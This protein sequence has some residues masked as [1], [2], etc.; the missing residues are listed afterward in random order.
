MLLSVMLSSCSY[1]SLKPSYKDDYVENTLLTYAKQGNVDAQKLIGQME[2][3]KNSGDIGDK[4]AKAWQDL[5]SG[6]KENSTTW[7]LTAAQ[8]GSW[9]AQVMLGQIADMG[10]SEGGSMDV[11][12]ELLRK[13]A[14][15][16][17]DFAEFELIKRI[18]L[19]KNQSY[20]KAQE[21]DEARWTRY[22]ERDVGM[23]R[24]ML[25]IS[26]MYF[27]GY[28][29]PQDKTKSAFWFDK[30]MDLIAS[31]VDKSKGSKRVLR[32]VYWALKIYDRSYP[33]NVNL[34]RWLFKY[35]SEGHPQ[36]QYDLAM[37]LYLGEG[38]KQNKDE[39]YKWFLK[40]AEQGY[41]ESMFIVG[42]AYDRGG[43]LKEDAE[44]ASYWYK[45]ASEQNYVRAQMALA[46]M[47][48]QGRGVTKDEAMAEKL[49]DKAIY[50]TIKLAIKEHKSPELE[51]VNL[52]TTPIIGIEDYKEMFKW[53]LKAA[54]KGDDFAQYQTAQMLENGSGTEK[55]IREAFYWYKNSAD[56]GNSKALVRIA[57]FYMDKDNGVVI[58]SPEEAIKWLMIPAEKKDAE[59]EYIL[60]LTYLQGEDVQI[61]PGFASKWLAMAA[62]QG[63]I[64]AGLTIARAYFY[65]DKLNQDRKK[66]LH[67]FNMVES[68]S[69]WDAK[70]I[71]DEVEI[72][73]LKKYKHDGL[74]N[75]LKEVGKLY[76]L[77]HMA[78]DDKDAEAQYQLARYFD[79]G[80][81]L[82]ITDETESTYWYETASKKG[83]PK[84]QFALAYRYYKGDDVK[85]NPEYSAKIMRFAA[86]KDYAPAEAYMG[87]Y[88][89]EGYGVEKNVPYGVT[90]YSKA[91]RQN[92][93]EAE[94]ALGKLYFEGEVVEKNWR[95][96][97]RLFR[98]AGV[99]KH[100]ESINHYCKI[101]D[102]SDIIPKGEP[103][104]EVWCKYEERKQNELEN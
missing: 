23:L 91:V 86:D 6:E 15:E 24:Y 84:A 65:G 34:S 90:F 59:A 92:Y 96:A 19:K 33:A 17:S 101:Y 48:K 82:K 1:F 89:V 83:Y 27:E 63:H 5:G 76:A 10:R 77:Y 49:I 61:N 87:K 54:R 26:R 30:A 56:N 37:A 47:M 20:A 104:A 25:G 94:Y 41:P 102:A 95:L 8:N 40:S 52:F 46:Y 43:D 14:K 42:A 100:R 9:K 58:Y 28:G 74:G 66:A 7:L 4:Y 79:Y 81:T 3:S 70:E 60:G 69:E 44:V 50:K 97:A 55:N 51:V 57:Q 64:M 35:A 29:L 62:E 16:G 88:Y 31:R 53:Y 75:K 80:P 36:F 103:L 68:N 38:I 13:F 18:E 45:K 71:L 72:G 93:D 99:Q 22:I 67:W 32:E 85:E 12:N 98:K 78:E 73:D 2:L 21:P 11:S 39:A